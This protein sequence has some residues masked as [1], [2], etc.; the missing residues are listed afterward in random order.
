MLSKETFLRLYFSREGYHLTHGNTARSVV[1]HV[2]SAGSKEVLTAEKKQ[3]EL[4]SEKK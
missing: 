3:E 4:E 1:G 2:D